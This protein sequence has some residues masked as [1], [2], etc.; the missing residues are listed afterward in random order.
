MTYQIV[1]LYLTPG[2]ANRAMAHHVTFQVA[3]A[4]CFAPESSSRTCTSEDDKAHTRKHGDWFD[5]FRAEEAQ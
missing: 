2:K 1:R 3:R 4:H 5:I